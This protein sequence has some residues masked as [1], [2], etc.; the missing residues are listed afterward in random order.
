MSLRMAE[1]RFDRTNRLG[2]SVMFEGHRIRLGLGRGCGVYRTFLGQ[3]FRG[4][5]RVA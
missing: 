2:P 5:D 1:G 4:L 3:P